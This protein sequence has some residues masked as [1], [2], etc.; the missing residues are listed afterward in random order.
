WIFFLG[1]II[2]GLTGGNFSI[3]F[4]YVADITEPEERG[5]LFGR[6]AA[7]SGVGFIAGPAIGGFMARFGLQ[8][9]FFLAAGLVTLN[10][11]LAI[12]ALPESLRPE[13]RV[14]RIRVWDLNPIKQLGGIFRIKQLRWLLVLGVCY[15]FPFVIMVS[16]MGVLMID[17][18]HWDAA[19]IGL[20]SLVVGSMDILVQGVLVQRLLPRFG[21]VR[22]LVVGLGGVMLGYLALG[23]VAILASPVALIAG[24]ALFAGFGGLVEP[25]LAGLTSRAAGAQSQGAVQ[26]GSQALQSL[27]AIFGPLWA[28]EL[29]TNAGGASPYATAAL[30]VGLGIFL[31]LRAAPMLRAQTKPSAADQT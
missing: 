3:L 16:N 25:T 4:A 15:M 22:L 5:K 10:L 21:E 13:H 19:R 6:F 8:T 26:G 28:G 27:T 11:L 23:S 12:F 7:I 17:H 14:A 20:V 30:I 24:I 9:P 1:R 2:D 29:Y 31:V 18:L